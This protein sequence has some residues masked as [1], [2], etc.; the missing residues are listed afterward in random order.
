MPRT[1]PIPARRAAAGAVPRPRRAHRAATMP[2]P[3]PT[4]RRRAGWGLRGAALPGL[5]RRAQPRAAGL[6]LG[7]LRGDRLDPRAPARGNQHGGGPIARGRRLARRQ[8]ADALG[9]RGRGADVAA[10]SAPSPRSR[11]PLDLAAGGGAIGRGL[12]PA[13]L[14]RACSCATMKPKALA[15]LRAASRAC[16]IATALLAARDLYELRQRLHRAAARLS[17]TR[18]TTGGARSAKPHLH[19]IRIPALV[20]QR[21]QRSLH[22][23]RRAC[24]DGR[25]GRPHVTLWQPAHGGH[26]RVFRCGG[27]Q[28]TCGACPSA[29]RWSRALALP[30]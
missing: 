29:V 12:Q 21:A 11:S 25:R 20:A 14:H 15:K 2:R 7:R 24:R 3:L 22:A 6:P 8:C 13:G 18:T 28:A 4:S 5:Q 1:G 17:A 26:V 19:R 23:R 30:R 16:S 27:P 10:W 9:R